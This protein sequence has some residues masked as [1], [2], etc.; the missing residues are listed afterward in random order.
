MVARLNDDVSVAQAGVEMREIARALQQEHPEAYP[1]GSGWSAGVKPLRE[2]LASGADAALWI[3][4]VAVTA[5]MLLGCANVAGLLIARHLDSR[6][7][8][9]VSVALGASSR[10]LLLRS[11]CEGLLVGGASG[12]VGLVGAEWLYAAL[13]HW[14]PEGVPR[15]D[16]LILDPRTL[17]FALGMTAVAGALA[18]LV[19]ALRGVGESADLLRGTRSVTDAG[20]RR[21]RTLLA[22]AQVAAAV[23]LLVVGGYAARSFAR[24][25]ATDVGFVTSDVVTA[26]LALSPL[27]YPTPPAQVAFFDR[28]EH[29]L[30]QEPGV[31]AVAA[32]SILPLSGFLNDS[33]FAVEGYVPTAPG[34]LPNAQTRVVSDDYFGA[35]SIPIE[36]GRAFDLRDAVDAPQVAIV[37]ASLARRFWPNGD[38]VGRRINRFPR[39]TDRPW[40][41]VVGIVG[42]VRHL[43]PMQPPEPMLYYPLRQLPSATISVLA[44]LDANRTDVIARGPRMLADV[45]RAVDPEQPVWLAR[46]MEDWRALST[47]DA[48]LTLSLLALFGGVAVILAAVGLFGVIAHGVARRRREFGVR[49]ALGAMPSR[50]MFG[51]VGRGVV[52]SA[53][54]AA[55]GLGVAGVT[56]QALAPVFPDVEVRD[57]WVWLAVI[58]LVAVVTVAAALVPA[59]RAMRVNP[60]ETLRAD[61]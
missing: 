23:T 26:R 31:A 29:A 7:E 46:T 61:G 4:S 22:T 6:H 28:L 11:V 13:Q 52:M 18:A 44:R 36:A 54:G 51:V 37:S 15:P 20:T 21:M 8:R 53:I 3:L 59:R 30:Q 10:R 57:P 47:E 14:L 56:G 58:G 50:L 16:G 2:V 9:A 48:K 17:T 43:N 5:L 45:V 19:S 1:D 49:L 33:S 35:L 41:T 40:T 27:R 42:D 39:A 24:L 25:V 34:L 38:A 55:L 60:I 12:A 32:I